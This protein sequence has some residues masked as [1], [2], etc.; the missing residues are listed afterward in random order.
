MMHG[1]YVV[2]TVAKTR[3]IYFLS[4]SATFLLARFVSVVSR[5]TGIGNGWGNVPCAVALD[6]FITFFDLL[7]YNRN[8]IMSVQLT[9]KTDLFSFM[10]R[11]NER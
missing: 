5:K 7:P 8:C 6:G 10:A 3:T 1:I 11:I 9:Y 4:S 2:N